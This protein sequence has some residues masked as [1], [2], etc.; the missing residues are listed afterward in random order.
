[1]D[2]PIGRHPTDRKRYVVKESGKSAVTHYRVLERF[3]HHTLILA[4]LETGRTHQIRVHMSHI[5]YPLLGDPVY[6]GRFRMPPDCNE[7]LDE[8]L[9][10]FKRQALHAAKLGLLHPV[11]QGYL[12]WEQALPEDMSRLLDALSENEQK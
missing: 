2:E 3:G 10:H 11:T 1:V 7:K 9:R 5:H 12:E 8:A 4:M 6:G